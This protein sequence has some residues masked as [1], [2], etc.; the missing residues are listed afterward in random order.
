MH[1]DTARRADVGTR[2]DIGSAASGRRGSPAA[3]TRDRQRRNSSAAGRACRHRH[4]AIEREADQR[5]QGEFGDA[6]EADDDDPRDRRACAASASS[7]S[8]SSPARSARAACAASSRGATRIWLAEKQ[9]HARPHALDGRRGCRRAAMPRAARRA[10]RLG[11]S[12]TARR[13]P[14]PQIEKRPRHR[15]A[16]PRPRACSRR[17]RRP[18]SPRCARARS[19]RIVGR[20]EP[21]AIGP[22]NLGDAADIGRD[23]RHPRRRR[24]QHDI[25]QRFRAR[26]HHEDPP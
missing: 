19:S 5:H 9:G 10:Q 18:A 24:L 7:R 23:H 8:S 1:A 21:V 17:G 3:T 25:G 15:P 14:W 2:I 6:R 22:E 20:T 16:A 11:D 12:R 13:R 26:R 4:E